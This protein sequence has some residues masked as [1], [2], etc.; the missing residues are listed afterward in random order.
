[1]KSPIQMPFASVETTLALQ[2]ERQRQA[3]GVA[4]ADGQTSAKRRSGSG[5]EVK[6]G[7]GYEENEDEL[8][9]VCQQPY[10][11]DTAMISCDTCTE[12]YHLKCV[13]LSQ[14]AAHNLKK[15]TCP[16][17]SALKVAC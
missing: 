16:V 12:W 2:E 6:E 3:S 5:G 9:C 7:E 1:M 11:V 10:N 13:S 14:S 4:P 15:Y 8:F 17:C